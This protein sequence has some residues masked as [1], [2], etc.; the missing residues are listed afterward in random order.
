MEMRP[1]VSQFAVAIHHPTRSVVM[2]SYCTLGLLLVVFLMLGCEQQ[3]QPAADQNQAATETAPAQT[4]LAKAHVQ[5]YIDRLLG[6]DQTVKGGLLGL[7]GV[8]FN[9]IESIQISSS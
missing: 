5:K 4:E 1:I 8:D 6:G 7:D 2:K 3:S 9:S